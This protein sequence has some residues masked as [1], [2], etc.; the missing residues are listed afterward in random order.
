MFHLLLNTVVLLTAP[1]HL[2]HAQ[3]KVLTGNVEE[4]DMAEM[5]IHRIDPVESSAVQ[6]TRIHRGE[7]S[8]SSEAASTRIH[9]STAVESGKLQELNPEDFVRK[10]PQA[11][12]LEAD[13]NSRVLTLAWEIWHKQ[14]IEAVHK[15]SDK[16][17][18]GVCEFVLTVTKDQHISV[19]IL[20]SSGSQLVV[21][22]LIRAVKSLDGNPGLAFPQGSRRQ[23]VHDS[24]IRE[25]G[26]NVK[27]SGVWGWEKNDF[28]Q[29]RQ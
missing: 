26:P 17:G 4:T 25:C 14:L 9:K 12:D 27:H 10:T 28:E 1:G 22:D 11:F 29:I 13:A 19:E 7:A 3:N 5:R 18:T 8:N 23:V 15:R 2:V 24:Y 20:H 6:P 21:Q 16:S